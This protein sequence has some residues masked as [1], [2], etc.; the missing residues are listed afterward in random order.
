MEIAALLMALAGAFFL[1]TAFQIQFFKQPPF[2]LKKHPDF[3]KSDGKW[4][5][6]AMYYFACSVAS[7]YFSTLFY[8]ASSDTTKILTV[9]GICAALVLWRK[10]LMRRITHPIDKH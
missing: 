8:W 3:G 2:L 1:W 5:V 4:R 7:I 9:P 6:F 10:I